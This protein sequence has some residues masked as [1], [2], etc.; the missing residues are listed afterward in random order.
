MNALLSEL[1]ARRRNMLIGAGVGGLVFMA[2]GLILSPYPDHMKQATSDA[3]Q[4]VA[5]TLGNAPSSTRAQLSS[6]AANFAEAFP[7]LAA[8]GVS[9][10]T[11][12]KSAMPSGELSYYVPSKPEFLSETESAPQAD[13]LRY[14][15]M[16]GAV[17]LTLGAA[18]GYVTY[19]RQPN[20]PVLEQ[21]PPV[22]EPV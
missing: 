13:W 4:R 9:K 18:A 8:D 1:P 11:D 22:S 5:A 16:V 21:V 12:T 6:D 17:S 14:A 15:A 7:L 3:R 10:I 2:S 19:R 20:S